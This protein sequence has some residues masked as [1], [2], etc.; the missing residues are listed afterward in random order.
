LFPLHGERVRVRANP[1]FILKSSNAHILIDS[2]LSEL[3]VS[4]RCRFHRRRGYAISK[5]SSTMNSDD[6]E[7]AM[8]FA[9]KTMNS[10]FSLMMVLLLI[11][12]S[13]SMAQTILI[14]STSAA[15]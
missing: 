15:P 4:L 10:G 8:K 2:I 13:P 6:R 5:I 7:I 1:K 11:G 14:Y 12:T 9:F 3:D